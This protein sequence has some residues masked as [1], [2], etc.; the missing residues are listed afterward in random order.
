MRPEVRHEIDR[1]DPMRHTLTALLLLALSSGPALAKCGGGFGSFVSGL[2]AEAVSKGH[3]KATVDR[4]F[5]GVRQDGAV[6]KADR[7]QG[8]FQCKGRARIGGHSI[9]QP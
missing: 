5:A 2:K 6:L 9:R 8:V 3:S 1:E 7:A 4:F